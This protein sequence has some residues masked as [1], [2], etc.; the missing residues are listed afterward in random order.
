ME[1]S[2]A[3]G[4]HRRRPDSRRGCISG[5]NRPTPSTGRIRVVAA[6]KLEERHKSALRP[7]KHLLLRATFGR[8][9][10]WQHTRTDVV[11]AKALRSSHVPITV[12]S[13][14]DI[15]GRSRLFDHI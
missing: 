4:S 11:A 12:V 15:R 5:G 14:C 10:M 6:L 3:V 1:F 2:C 13:T 9:H 7:F 8:E